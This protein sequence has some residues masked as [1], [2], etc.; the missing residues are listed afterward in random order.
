MA[1]FTGDGTGVRGQ[2]GGGEAALACP[3]C[4]REDQVLGV[5]A[6]YLRAKAKLSVESK[7]GDGDNVT[8][9]EENSA[10]AKALAIAPDEPDDST[11]G[12]LGALLVLVS[13]GA[14]IWG[15]VAG[16]WFESDTVPRFYGGDGDLPF[17]VED[18][19]TYLGWISAA[20]LLV[21]PL[22]MALAGRAVRVWRR[23]T[24]PGRVA[25]DRVWAEGWYCGRCGVV[26]FA[27]ERAM[28][29]QEFRTRVWSAGGYGDLAVRHPAV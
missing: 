6:A 11:L 15:A 10:L 25:A 12:C 26:H 17:G 24:E 3:R 29:L 8:T 4:G 21:G 2:G 13:I 28:S 5:S 19:T 14:F 9:R 1:E 7:G 23:R 20:S 27:G 22:L 16:K 18:S